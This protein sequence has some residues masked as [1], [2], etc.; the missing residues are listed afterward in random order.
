MS[1]PTP[2]A[3]EAT[4]HR[5]YVHVTICQGAGQKAHVSTCYANF[6]VFM[7]ILWLM[8]ARFPDS[9]P[10]RARQLCVAQSD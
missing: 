10:V 3:Y 1:V 6:R 9:L 7:L 5:L 2:N 4:Y 8:V